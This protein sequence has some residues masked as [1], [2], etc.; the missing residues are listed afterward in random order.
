MLLHFLLLLP[1]EQ[2][3]HLSYWVSTSVDISF[4]DLFWLKANDTELEKSYLFAWIRIWTCAPNITRW[5]S[6]YRSRLESPSYLIVVVSGLK[7]S[8]WHELNML[9]ILKFGAA[10]DTNCFGDS[11][12]CKST[13]SDRSWNRYIF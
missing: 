8:I 13:P 12:K 5:F 3:N 11:E 10:N 1:R 4:K 7:A 9:V 6:K 2:S